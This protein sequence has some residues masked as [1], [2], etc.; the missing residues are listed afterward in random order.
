MFSDSGNFVNW[1]AIH[2][3]FGGVEWTRRYVRKWRINITLI[4]IWSFLAMM[5]HIVCEFLAYYS[6]LRKNVG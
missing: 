4:K 3:F 1:I 2:S 5:Q 6:S